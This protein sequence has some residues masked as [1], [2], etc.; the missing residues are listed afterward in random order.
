[1][2]LF[3]SKDLIEHISRYNDEY[4]CTIVKVE[5]VSGLIRVHIDERGDMSLG[6]DFIDRSIVKPV[7]F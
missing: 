5:F 4:Y 7:V 3:E 1:M 6:K 2:L